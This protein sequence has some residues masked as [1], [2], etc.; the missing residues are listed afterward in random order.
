MK[1]IEKARSAVA[2]LKA[3]TEVYR[4]VI[5]HPRTPRL[6]RILLGAAVAYA[7][8]PID[9]IPDFIPVLGHLD[10]LL[11]LPILVWTAIRLVPAEV[12]RECREAAGT[13]GPRIDPEPGQGPLDGEGPGRT[14]LERSGDR[15]PR[16]H[17]VNP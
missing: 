5:R 6:S 12:V 2:R 11:L 1:A 8:S 16:R 17:V 15:P 10:D 3:E 13:C 9:L 7:L 14:R 4:L